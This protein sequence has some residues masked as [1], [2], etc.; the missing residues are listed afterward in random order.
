[1][2]FLIVAEE[3]FKPQFFVRNPEETGLPDSI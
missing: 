1:M 2:A 3:I